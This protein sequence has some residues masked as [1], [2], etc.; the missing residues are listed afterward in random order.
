ME[1][2]INPYFV[3]YIR[4]AIESQEVFDKYWNELL[5]TIK[6]RAWCGSSDRMRFEALAFDLIKVAILNNFKLKWEDQNEKE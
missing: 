4:G 1:D 5:C 2:K 6:N 3:R